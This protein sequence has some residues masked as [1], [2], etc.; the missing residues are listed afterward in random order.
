MKKFLFSAVAV[1]FCLGL[2]AQDVKKIRNAYD[3]KDWPKAK[4]AVD[5]AL[6][7]EKE[8]KN[9]EAWYY[10]GLIYGQIAKDANLKATVPDAWM[11]SFEAYQKAMELDKKQSEVFMMTR[12]Y[13]VFENYLELQKEANTFYNSG[14]YQ[15]AL[16]GY[17]KADKVG[18]FIFA[19]KWALSEVDTI[20][21]YYAGAAA[22]QLENKEEVIPFF[23]KLADA[24]IGGEGYDVVYRY[25]TYYYDQKKDAEAAKKYAE[26]GRKLYPKDMY[27]DRLEL[28]KMRKSGATALDIFKKYETIMAGEPKDYELRY[29]YA[30]EIFNWLYMDSKATAEQK[31]EYFGKIIST[32]KNCIELDAK[33]P[34][35]HLLLG[36]TYFNEAAFMQ[37]E[38]KKVKGTTPADTQKKTEMKKQM[39]DKMKEALPHLDNSLVIYSG[40]T[41]D[42]LKDKRTNNEYKSTLYLLTEAH[43]FLG[44]K[45]KEK[46][47]DA[48]YQALNQ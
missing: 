24:N 4:E 18:R 25:L 38:M 17:K 35:A 43:R 32:L 7:N 29:D 9:W 20:L 41:A 23:Q 15:G 16:D 3:K 1:L 14:N 31:P 27:Y 21:Y 12:Q 45:D 13:P 28:D 47:F 8:Q 34:D 39:E 36:K 6:A 33:Q 46:E 19:N 10:K 40:M 22:M 37:D 42:Q 26:A 44:N 5:L 11:Q 30:A 48:K 2:S